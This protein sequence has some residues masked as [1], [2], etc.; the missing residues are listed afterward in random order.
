[1]LLLLHWDRKQ[2][3]CDSTKNSDSHLHFLFI[4]DGWPSHFHGVMR[5][6]EGIVGDLPLELI[7][8]FRMNGWKKKERKRTNSR[9]NEIA[10]EED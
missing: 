2:R 10:R 1:M 8:P 5:K 3:R 7:F 4:F 6:E 9:M